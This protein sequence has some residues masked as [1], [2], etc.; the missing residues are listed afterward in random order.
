MKKCFPIFIFLFSLSS[1]SVISNNKQEK[2]L[3]DEANKPYSE[4]TEEEKKDIDN[5]NYQQKVASDQLEEERKKYFIEDYNSHLDAHRKFGYILPLSPEQWKKIPPI[6]RPKIETERN[7]RNN[8]KSL[9]ILTKI[10][11]G[12]TKN[13]YQCS[14]SENE[15][16]IREMRYSSINESLIWNYPKL[17]IR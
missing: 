14:M 1:C 7:I 4:L 11:G 2:I 5:K 3:E 8:W 13:Y 6:Y 15:Y 10:N 12:N 17:F 9:C 16:T